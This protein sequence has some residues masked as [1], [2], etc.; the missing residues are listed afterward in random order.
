MRKNSDTNTDP[1]GTPAL[2]N[3]QLED[4]PFETTL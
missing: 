2:I 3:S 4:W 1:W